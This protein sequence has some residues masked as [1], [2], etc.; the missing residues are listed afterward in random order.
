MPSK[1]LDIT[2]EYR[3]LTVIKSI[4]QIIM[5]ICAAATQAAN[6]P[7]ILAGQNHLPHEYWATVGIWK[8]NLQV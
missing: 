2:I 6:K 3:K 7:E 1:Y 4:S 5:E 8:T